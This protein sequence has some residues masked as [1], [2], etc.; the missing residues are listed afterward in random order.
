MSLAVLPARRRQRGPGR[1][2]L[3]LL[4]AALVNLALFSAL[5]RLLAEAPPSA[6]PPV[7]PISRALPPPPAAPPPRPVAPAAQRRPVAP[8]AMPRLDL[9]VVPTAHAI[10]QAPAPIAIPLPPLAP[11]AIAPLAG[12]EG[13]LPAPVA[14]PAALV[15][16]DQL[17]EGVRSFDRREP[18]FPV[19]AQRLGLTDTVTVS[20][21]VHADGS[22]T[23]L[24]LVS[25]RHPDHFREPS[26]AC[27]RQTRFVPGRK[28]GQAVDSRCLWTFHYVL[29][30][31]R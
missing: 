8:P 9:G 14:Q 29:P 26:F 25:A 3:A 10:A 15:D 7:V 31:N 27:V 28:A 30:A 20:F 1:V 17:D 5:A 2:A 18:E 16:A 24:E 4:V 13:G 21:I 12:L 19:R 22:V 23:D 6:L 11:A